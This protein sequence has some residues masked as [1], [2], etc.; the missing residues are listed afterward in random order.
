MLATRQPKIVE[1]RP[2]RSDQ[3]RRKSGSTS[4]EGISKLAAFAIPAYYSKGSILF[5]EGQ[6]T[7]GVFILPSG[8]VKLFTSSACGRNFY[9]R[10]CQSRGDTWLGRDDVRRAL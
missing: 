9:S 2:K 6:P 3:P 1:D 8:R 5:V 7:R 4:P 10:V